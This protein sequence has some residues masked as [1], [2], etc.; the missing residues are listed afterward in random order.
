[1]MQEYAYFHDSIRNYAKQIG[2]RAGAEAFP[3]NNQCDVCCWSGSGITVTV[4]EEEREAPGLQVMMDCCMKLGHFAKCATP[5]HLPHPNQRHYITQ[6]VAL[7]ALPEGMRAAA[8]ALGR[9]AADPAN[10]EHVTCSDHRAATESGSLKQRVSRP[11]L[12]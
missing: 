3:A 9:T 4:D 2:D 7:Q 12:L 8:E 1:M 10:D 11:R 6:E 5:L